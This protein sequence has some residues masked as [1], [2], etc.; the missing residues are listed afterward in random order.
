MNKQRGPSDLVKI[1]L[2][3]LTLGGWYLY[4]RWQ[5]HQLDKAELISLLP[6]IEKATAEFGPHF[7]GNKY[8]AHYDYLQLRFRHALLLSK[9]PKKYNNYNLSDQ[10]FKTI[11]RFAGLHQGITKYRSDYNRE[12]TN[13][14][15]VGYKSFFSKLEKYPLS[16]EQMHAVVSEEDNSL[17]IAGAGT[18]KTTT[19]SAKIAYLLDKKLARPQELLV[20]SFTNAAV[21]EMFERT[22]RFCGKDSGVEQATFRTFNSFGNQVVRYCNPH[23]K[24]I[25]FEGK[26]YK[27]KAFLQQSF[28]SL[29]KT[30]EDFQSKAISFL[31]FFN[32]PVKDQFEFNSAAEF[33]N[34]QQ[35][36]RCISLSGVEVKSMEELQIANFL[37][38]H[39]V[40]FEYESRFPL[41]REDRNPDFGNYAPDFYLP[42]YDIY[43][44]HY[45]IDRNGDVPNWFSAKPPFKTAREYY[46]HGMAWK[47][48]I[49]EKYGTRL[50]KTYSYQSSDGSMLLSLKKQL[51]ALG[52]MLRKRHPDEIIARLK[53]TE[54]FEGF[55]GLI[56]TFLN[57]MKSSGMMPGGLRIE[58]MEQRF[59]VFLD[60]FTPLFNRYE[61][62]LK[63]TSCIDFND[64]VNHAASYIKNG[65]YPKAYKYILV[66]EFQ[67]MSQGRYAM[68][69]ALK[70]ANPSAK[71]YAVG[72]DWQSVYRF[73]GSDVS[74]IS[75][76]SDYF[77][78]TAHN[79]ILQTYRFNTEI[80]QVSSTFIQKNPAQLRKKLSSPFDADIPAFGLIPVDLGRMKKAE[81]DLY[82]FDRINQILSGIARNA[83]NSC[84][85]LIGR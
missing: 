49:H 2:F 71:L 34:H 28:D 70:K 55:I 61:Q 65:K 72:D 40:D 6:E 16:L 39:Q 7:S 24:Q 29:F 46:H 35:S 9:I 27:V 44:E 43:H 78:V 21:E 22:L 31:A 58:G 5:Q 13:S 3:I 19:I 20:I 54:N 25:A 10:E 76:F 80:L 84:V 36:Q 60:V 66:D 42:G 74:I 47:Q 41:E 50:I 69:D 37:Y 62:K 79:Q 63:D 11:D 52:V 85:F 32:R 59:Y 77:G 1:I 56:Y 26:D 53:K 82:L 51:S 4:Y 57:L 81:I 64:M 8:F 17:V 45:G 73:N 83:P 23:P 38:L 75:R 18:G 14:E 48:H 67:D 12:F 68:L 30:D 15:I 33:K